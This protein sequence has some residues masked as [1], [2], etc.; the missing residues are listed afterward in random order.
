MILQITNDGWFGDF[1]PG[2]EHHMLLVRWRAAELNTPVVRCANTGISALIDANGRDITGVPIAARN[3]REWTTVFTVPLADPDSVTLFARGGWMVAW[4]AI[5]ACAYLL[6]WPR[7]R[8]GRT[9]AAPPASDR[10]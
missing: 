4:L 3:Q 2:K 9:I 1:T 7:P 6:F 5:P 10:S 8:H